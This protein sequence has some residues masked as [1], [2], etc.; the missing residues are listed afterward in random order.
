MLSVV[1]VWDVVYCVWRLVWMRLMAV[2]VRAGQ[3]TRI[4]AIL[5]LRESTS[6]VHAKQQGVL[7]MRGVLLMREAAEVGFGA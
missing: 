6:P 1:N 4:K 7:E 5:P 2:L 3:P